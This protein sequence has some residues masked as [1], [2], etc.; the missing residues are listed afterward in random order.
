MRI[1]FSLSAHRTAVRTERTYPRNETL[2]EA[3]DTTTS[4]NRPEGLYHGLRAVRRHLRLDDFQ[5]LP[6]RR[7]FKL[8][9]R[10]CSIRKGIL[11]ASIAV[12]RVPCS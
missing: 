10:V 12:E 3:R 6:E 4:P 1:Q 5:G 2:V 9:G 8:N 7:N 11:I